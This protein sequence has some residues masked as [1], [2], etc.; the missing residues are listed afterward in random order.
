MLY[1]DTIREKQLLKLAAQ[2]GVCVS[3]FLPTTPLTQAAQADRVTFKN[4]S[5]AAMEQ[6][7]A[8]ADKRQIV[9]MTEALEELQADD[10]F[11]EFQANGLGVLVTP[12]SINTFRLAYGVEEAAEVSD[13]FH[14]KPLTSALQPMAAYVLAISQKSVMLYEFTAAQELEELDVSDLPADFSDVTKVTLQRDRS[15]VGKLQGDEG[16]DVLQ[17]QFL[18][19]VE[20]AVRPI[21]SGSNMPLILATTKEFQSMYQSLNSYELL[22]EQGVDGSTEGIEKEDIRQAVL[23]ITKMLRQERIE[24]WVEL[25]HQRKS[26]SRTNTDLPTIAKLVLRGQVSHLLV[27]SGA[28]QYGTLS[29]LGEITTSDSRSANTYDLIDE[30]VIKVIENGGEVLGVRREEDAPKDLMPMAAILRWA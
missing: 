14:L 13:R 19:G 1:K 5:K 6:A 18:R 16:A 20:S 29:D 28:V 26:E 2:R 9:A 23:P 17:R 3:I 15:P 21:I 8:I 25:F 27:E 22:V 30:I 4:L 10:E 24:Q 12:D 7:G 11:W